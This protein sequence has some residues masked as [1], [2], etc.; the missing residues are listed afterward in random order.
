M[1]GNPVLTSVWCPA[2]G[3]TRAA[4]LRARY[5]RAMLTGPLAFWDAMRHAYVIECGACALNAERN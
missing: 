4:D 2:C 5:W 1:S 3:R